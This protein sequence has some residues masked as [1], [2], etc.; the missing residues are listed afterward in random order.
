MSFCPGYIRI[1]WDIKKGVINLPELMYKR[2]LLKVS[3][4]ALAGEKKT[5]LDAEKVYTLDDGRS[6][7]GSTLMN[8][9][10]D[11]TNVL[12]C[13]ANCVMLHFKA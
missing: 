7:H 6:F 2:V 9:G 12:R 8:V 10:V 3:G 4:E 11:V 13:D 5:G 1:D